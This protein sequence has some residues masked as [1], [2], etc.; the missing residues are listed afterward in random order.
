MENLEFPH[1]EDQHRH[2]ERK[3]GFCHG[4]NAQVP[5]YGRDILLV[6]TSK[7]EFTKFYLVCRWFTLELCGFIKSWVFCIQTYVQ[8]NRMALL[9]KDTKEL[10]KQLKQL[11]F[12]HSLTIPFRIS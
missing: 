9:A 1:A 5:I 12:F 8:I 7:I 2:P 6:I 4:Y 11:Y 10:N 3:H